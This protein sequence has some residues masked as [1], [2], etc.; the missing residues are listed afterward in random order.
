MY[1]PIE[2]AVRR[3]ERT[4]LLTSSNH[5]DGSAVSEV[6]HPKSSCRIRRTAQSDRESIPTVGSL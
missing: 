1:E 2:G 4:A 3:L 6:L 5:L